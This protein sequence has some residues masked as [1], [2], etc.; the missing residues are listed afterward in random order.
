M[1]REEM[2]KEAQAQYASWGFYAKQ[3]NSLTEEER[4]EPSIGGRTRGQ[5]LQ[6]N[7][8]TAK[9][10]WEYLTKQIA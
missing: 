2:I 4:N 10:R 7:Y 5:Y 9:A 6:D 3:Y 8:N 1:S